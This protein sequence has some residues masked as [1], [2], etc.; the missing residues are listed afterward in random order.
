[1]CPPP[2]RPPSLHTLLLYHTTTHYRRFSFA[3]CFS[4]GRPQLSPGL[5]LAFLIRLIPPA[6][7]LA[8]P[9]HLRPPLESAAL[10]CAE[11]RAALPPLTA[12]PL[13]NTI[14]PSSASS[15]S[16]SPSSFSFSSPRRLVT[17][18]SYSAPVSR[19]R[20]SSHDSSRA[21]KSNCCPQSRPHTPRSLHLTLTL[22]P[23]STSHPRFLCAPN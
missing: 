4:R 20:A 5:L 1:M 10:R 6:A 8:S 19:P 22:R 14:S 23:L 16:H 9:V 3:S 2:L 15:P 11:L 17:F 21:N 13:H 7:R 18:A 12:R